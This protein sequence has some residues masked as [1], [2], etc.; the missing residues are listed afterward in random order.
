MDNRLREAGNLLFVGL[1]QFTL[2]VHLHD[3][4]LD[5][6]YPLGPFCEGPNESEVILLPTGRWRLLGSLSKIR[7]NHEYC[8]SI[9]ERISDIPYELY[10]S[11][12]E[13]NAGFAN[14][15]ESLCARARSVGVNPYYYAIVL[16]KLF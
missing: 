11:Y 8:Q 9:A 7:D 1:N 12:G 13:N 15:Y 16:L 4:K 5:I 10:Q 14:P 2:T 3:N 6:V